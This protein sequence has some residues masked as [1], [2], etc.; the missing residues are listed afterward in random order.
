MEPEMEILIEDIPD[1][2][3]EV[4]A[5][6]LEPWLREVILASVGDAF[7]EDDHASLNASITRIGKNITI[8][9]TLQFTSHPDCDRC[10]AHYN[11]ESFIPL[12]TVLAPLYE[13]QRQRE[14]GEGMDSGLVKEDL[15]FGYYEG[16][17]FDLAEIVQEQL[18]LAQP[19]KHLCKDNCLGLCQRC[20][21]DLNAGPCKCQDKSTHPRWAPLKG[22]KL[23]KKG[24]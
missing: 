13:N 6:G 14:R 17:R 7:E 21:K 19:M 18:V 2:G 23:G 12:Y 11:D 16:D 5:T 20:G 24:G 22:V 8:D 9:G 1:E 3:L 4:A 10:L 15:E